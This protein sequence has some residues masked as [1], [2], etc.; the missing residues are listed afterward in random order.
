L[1]SLA[2]ELTWIQY[3]QLALI[4]LANLQRSMFAQLDLEVDEKQPDVA[5]VLPDVKVGDEGPDWGSTVC[6]NQLSDLGKRELILPRPDESSL[7]N[8]SV[9]NHGLTAQGKLFWTALSLY[10]IPGPT[11]NRAANDLVEMWRLR[12]IGPPRA[13]NP[14]S[15]GIGEGLLG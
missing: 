9:R 11:S 6:M 3:I 4:E 2:N 10:R 1:I 5:Y 8:L 15:C 14:R 12:S 13:D 7:T